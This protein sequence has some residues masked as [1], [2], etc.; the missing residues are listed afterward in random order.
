MEK[1][2]LEKAIAVLE[3]FLPH[4]DGESFEGCHLSSVEGYRGLGP[5]L[6]LRKLILLICKLYQRETER[7]NEREREVGGREGIAWTG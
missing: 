7:E 5:E 2:S 3:F 4:H 1:V 6:P